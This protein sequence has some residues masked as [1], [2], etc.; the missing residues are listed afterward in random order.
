MRSTVLWSV[1]GLMLMMSA[2]KSSQDQKPPIAPPALA[3]QSAEI[4][5]RV[6]T[7]SPHPLGYQCELEVDEVHRYGANTRPLAKTNRLTVRIP[8]TLLSEPPTEG[9]IPFAPDTA[10]RLTV[11]HT[12]QAGSTDL[13][14][15]AVEIH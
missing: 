2:C 3:P 6:K 8:A 12:A 11:R 10:L 15:A 9:T 1:V 5:T 13:N 7:C 4:S 14:W